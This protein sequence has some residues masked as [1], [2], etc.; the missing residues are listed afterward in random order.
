MLGGYRYT[1]RKGCNRWDINQLYLCGGYAKKAPTA[2]NITDSLTK[3]NKS[4]N[5]AHLLEVKE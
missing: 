5:R 2:D 1:Y 4:K 3:F